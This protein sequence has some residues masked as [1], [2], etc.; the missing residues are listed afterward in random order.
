M[1]YKYL[2]FDLDGTL[3]NSKQGIKNCL[4]KGLES[5]GIEAPTD[6]QIT[7]MIGPPFRVS[8]R[9]FYNLEGEI[10]EQMN[11]IYRNEYD[12]HGWK[13]ILVYDGVV[14]MLKELKQK[15][16][17]LALATSKPIRYSQRI[18]DHF[19][20]SEYMDFVSGAS[21]DGKRDAKIDILKHIFEN[22]NIENKDEVVLVGDTKYDVVGANTMGIDCIGVDWGFG[23]RE[24]LLN[25]GAVEVFDFPKE[26]VQYL[27]K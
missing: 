4:I 15:G 18:C 26:V 22:L 8:M 12:I 6:E 14:E 7:K 23:T 24:D 10:V 16:Y 3:I 19:G 2:L 20:F 27:N 17:I 5:V 21:D 1:K 13:E 25:H 11:T 9:E